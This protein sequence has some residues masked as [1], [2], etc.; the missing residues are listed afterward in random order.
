[1]SSTI[2]LAIRV[3]LLLAVVQTAVLPRFPILGLVPQLPFLVALAWGLLRGMNEGIIWAFIGGLLLDL[4]SIAPMGATSFSFML[5]ILAVIWIENAIPADR[6]FVPVIMSIA[7]TVIN[8]LIYFILLRLLGYP[9]TLQGAAALLPTAIL[10]GALILPVYWLL[11]YLDR[12]FR[13]RPV[14]L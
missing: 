7:A 6:F 4:F 13:P 11:F 2:Y 9:T 5:A 12:T 10:H 1:M 14:Q 3:M 8:L